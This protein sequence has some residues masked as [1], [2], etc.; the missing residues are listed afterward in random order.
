MEVG[1][2]LGIGEA[3]AEERISRSLEK[4]RKL[5]G[6]KGLTLSATALSAAVAA[7]AVHAAPATLAAAISTAALY[8]TTATRLPLFSRPPNPSP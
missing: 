8:G 5:V 4:L 6:K 1:K 2:A 3:A 7:N